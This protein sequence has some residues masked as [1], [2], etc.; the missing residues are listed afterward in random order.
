MPS[1]SECGV[2]PLCWGKG[3]LGEG[4]KAVGESVVDSVAS[5]VATATESTLT[6]MAKAVVTT[7][8]VDV[9]SNASVEWLQGRVHYLSVILALLSILIAAAMMIWHQRGQPLVEL[10]ASLARLVLVAAA[11]V[12]AID[13]ATSAADAYAS[14]LL[15]KSG[16]MSTLAANMTL[17]L[18]QTGVLGAFLIIVLGLLSIIGGLIQ[19][20]LLMVRGVFLLLMAGIFPLS[21]SA[22]NTEWGKN[23][24]RKSLSWI[25]A[26][27]AYKPAVAIIFAFGM[28]M[29][30]TSGVNVKTIKEKIKEV[31][32]VDDPKPEDYS[33]CIED[34]PED[35]E[36]L[37][38]DMMANLQGFLQ[39]LIFILLAVFALSA[40]IKFIIPAAGALSSGSGAGLAAVAGGAGSMVVAS[41][42]RSVSGG[43][44]SGTSDGGGSS[45]GLAGGAGPSG[46]GGAGGKSAGGSP[47]G[48][49]SGSP[50]GAGEPGA[51]GASAGSMSGLSGAGGAGGK[52]AG[53]S[54]SGASGGAAAS[55]A[56][57]AAAGA[58]TAGATV[59]FQA[60]SQV[61]SGAKNMA[62]NQT[63]E[64]S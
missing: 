49:S 61:A 51:T 29:M 33:S 1:F 50:G 2:S 44:S 22:T 64:T 54:P 63:G 18:S 32:D 52:G 11:G 43:H 39:G 24:F 48:A 28:R 23:W 12:T 45:S 4:V 7:K 17:F 47:S 9:K 58:A 21:A 27:V 36:N 46:A 6:F 57:G 56:G 26:F 15:E 41:G 60:A 38:S 37:R 10:G 5:A 59:A 20:C 53:G 25:I 30:N 35:F 16:G 34:H 55:G 42:A 3:W 13:L 8:P 14:W 62:E 40:I 31:C 19:V